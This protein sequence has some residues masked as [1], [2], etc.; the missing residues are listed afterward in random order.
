MI[1]KYMGENLKKNTIS[2]IN[3]NSFI[4]YIRAHIHKNYMY[5]GFIQYPTLW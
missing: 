5:D 1:E 3:E 2:A 4:C